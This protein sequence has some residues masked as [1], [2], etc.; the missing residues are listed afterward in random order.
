M[1]FLSKGL[2]AVG[3]L[4]TAMSN[5]TIFFLI[6]AVVSATQTAK[7]VGGGVGEA[8]VAINRVIDLGQYLSLASFAGCLLIALGLILSFFVKAPRT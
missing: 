5:A 6:R 4:I 3:L 7:V 8:L 1:N 2:I